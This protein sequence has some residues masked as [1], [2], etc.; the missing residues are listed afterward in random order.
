MQRI[1]ILIYVL[2]FILLSC[3][4]HKRLNEKEIVEKPAEINKTARD[5]IKESLNDLIRDPTSKDLPPLKNALSIK[6]IYDQND[7]E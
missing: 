4:D 3:K 1:T 6:S 7:Y 2:S 5:I